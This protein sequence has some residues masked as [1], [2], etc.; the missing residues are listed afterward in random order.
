MGQADDVSVL[1]REPKLLKGRIGFRTH[2]ATRIVSVLY[3]EPKLLKVFQCFSQRGPLWVSVLY[4]EPKLLK[5]QAPDRSAPHDRVSV[6]YREPKLLKVRQPQHCDGCTREFQC[7]T[8]SR[9]C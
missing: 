3:R 6:L 7:S 8:V 4:R 2:F 1:Y 5:V 9:N